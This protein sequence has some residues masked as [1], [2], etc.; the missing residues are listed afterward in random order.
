MHFISEISLFKNDSIDIPNSQEAQINIL[1]I[2]YKQT[3][4]YW[5]LSP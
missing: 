3:L 2:I 1:N 4:A 5:L